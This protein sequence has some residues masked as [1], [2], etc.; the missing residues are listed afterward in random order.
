M[1]SFGFLNTRIG[2]RFLAIFLT[3]SLVPLLI[4]GWFALRSSQMAVSRQAESV[5]RAAADGA[6]AQLREFLKHLK[7]QTIGISEDKK[8]R[9]ILEAADAAGATSGPS[10]A[11]TDLSGLLARLHEIES[12]TEEIFVLTADGRVV[13]SSTRENIG[14]QFS[15][16]EF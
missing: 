1:R 5:L 12:D 11:A 8:I 3:I 14:K 13:A 2:R 9:E 4:A 15:S 6:E 16:R 10:S 7:E